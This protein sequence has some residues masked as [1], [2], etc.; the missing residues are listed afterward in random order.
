MVRQ[1]DVQGG[2]FTRGWF[3]SRNLGTFREY[4]HPQF[5]GSPF[6]Y[7][8]LGVFEAMSMRWMAQ[9]V[10]TS[11][12][13]YAVGVDPW[14]MTTKLDEEYM[15]AVKGRAHDNT[16][17]FKNVM[18]QRGSSA[19][20][21][22][23]MTGKKGFLGIYKDSVDLCMVDGNHNALAVLDDLRWVYKLMAPGGWILLDDVENDRE[24]Q[25]H[26]KQGLEMWKEEELDINMLWKHSYMECYKKAD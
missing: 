17:E 19:E 4:I 15:D 26:V 5:S 2:S 22:R 10:L 3:R 24:K 18:L 16:A 13:S 9:N 12:E 11:P 7:L 14:L 25:D 6:V 20:V 23:K 8:E 1:M 21:L